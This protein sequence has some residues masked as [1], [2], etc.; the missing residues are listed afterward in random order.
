MP[1]GGRDGEQAQA[2]RG[3]ERHRVGGAADP[4]PEVAERQPADPA[5]RAGPLGPTGGG[6]RSTVGRRSGPVR[7]GR[8]KN[9]PGHR[10]TPARAAAA[11]GA[12]AGP[13][14]TDRTSPR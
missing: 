8:V 9:A 14:G 3:Q 2:H 1:V 12:K 6:A 11:D 5:H 7:A 10:R 13:S 4:V